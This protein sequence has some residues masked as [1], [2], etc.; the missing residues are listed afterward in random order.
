LTER[1]IGEQLAGW[2][3]VALLETRGRV[4]GHPVRA[5]VGFVERVD[6]SLVVAAAS[7]ATG[8]ARNLAA[9]ARCRVVEGGPTGDYRARTLEGGERSAAVRDLILKYGGPSERLGSGPAFA[10]DPVCEAHHSRPDSPAR[11]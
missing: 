2:G 3:R 10:L 6:G 1:D 11:G 7:D 8:W 9:D 4:S 5:A